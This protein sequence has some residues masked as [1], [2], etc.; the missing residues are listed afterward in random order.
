MDDADPMQPKFRG[1]EQMLLS[2]KIIF[3]MLDL[4]SI[5]T[6]GTENIGKFYFV[7]YKIYDA[8]YNFSLYV[9]GFSTFSIYISRHMTT[10]HSK[11]VEI[12]TSL[13]NSMLELSLD[14]SY[15]LKE[16]VLKNN[17]L[18]CAGRI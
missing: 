5:S 13:A 1:D 12:I 18:Y 14:M 11:Y 9:L 6:N 2:Q 7:L 17:R 10:P 15:Q 8:L 16:M 4:G 3:P